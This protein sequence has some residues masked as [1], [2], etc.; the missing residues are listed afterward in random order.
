MINGNRLAYIV[1]LIIVM[2]LFAVGC[3]QQTAP[4]ADTG[5]QQA[6]DENAGKTDDQVLDKE[7]LLA[8]TTST[9]DSGLLDVLE[10]DFEE[11]TGYDLQIISKGTGASLK[12]GQNGDV[13]VLLVHAKDRELALVEEG[14][15]INRHDVM[16][17]DFIILGPEEDPAG[18]KGMTNAVE[19]FKKI[20]DAQLEF[21]SRGD[22]SGTN[23]KELAIWESAA[24][25]PTD[26]WYLSLGQGMGDT[27][28]VANEKQAYTLS[29]RG[30]YIA[31]KDKLNLKAL[32]EGDQI[33]FNQYGVMAVNPEKHNGINA[34]G[35]DAFIQYMLSPET[36]V[37]I[38][39]YKKY[40]EQLFTPNA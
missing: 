21:A 8:T 14:Y 22:N 7:L 11:K 12:L 19:A 40:G 26:D 18:V 4:P 16:Y 34:E 2:G 24:I 10:P 35:A 27:L 17:N 20:A 3:G 30:T 6:A 23:M 33:M 15:F 1:L 32:V 13:D 29:D 39:A 25:E 38:G 37:K 31:M 28:R 9:Y 5:K 36:Q